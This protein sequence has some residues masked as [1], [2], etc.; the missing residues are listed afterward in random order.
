MNSQ[1]GSAVDFGDFLFLR[2]LMV[3]HRCLLRAIL[4]APR[5]LAQAEAV[6]SGWVGVLHRIEHSRWCVS[7]CAVRKRE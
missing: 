6:A 7:L 1:E 3:W 5:S 4:R 2:A